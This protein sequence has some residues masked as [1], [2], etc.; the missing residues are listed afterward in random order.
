MLTEAAFDGGTVGYETTSFTSSACT[1]LCICLA[2]F[3]FAKEIGNC[4]QNLI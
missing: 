1:L 4:E 2:K 3:N